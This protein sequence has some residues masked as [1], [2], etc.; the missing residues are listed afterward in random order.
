MM[1]PARLKLMPLLGFILSLCVVHPVAKAQADTWRIHVL[2]QLHVTFE[3][4]PGYEQLLHQTQYEGPD[5]VVRRSWY[6]RDT[7]L[8]QLCKEISSAFRSQIKT[9]NLVSEVVNLPKGP[10]CFITSQDDSELYSAVILPYPAPQHFRWSSTALYDLIFTIRKKY[11]RQFAERVNFPP[12]LSPALYVEGVFELLKSTYYLHNQI[13]WNA[14]HRDMLAS[15]NGNN[16]MD[17]A[18]K[19]IKVTTTKFRELKD[20]HSYFELPAEAAATLRGQDSSMGI[21]ILSGEDGVIYLIYP[22]SPGAKAGLRVGDVLQTINGKPLAMYKANPA[23]KTLTLVVLRKSEPSPLTITV[24]SGSFQTYIPATGRR[25]NGSIGYIE[26]LGIDGDEAIQQKYAY[27]TQQAIRKV[28]NSATCGWIVDLRRNQGGKIAA[29]FSGIAP[30]IGEGK[31]FGTSNGYSDIIWTTYEGGLFSV[32]GTNDVNVRLVWDPYSLKLARPPIAVLTS[33]LTASGGEFTAIALLKRSE[34][35]T[36]IFGEHTR[37]LTT[38]LNG[39]WLY[40]DA[41]LSIATSVA[42]DRT[43]NPYLTGVEPDEKLSTDF[44]VFGSDDDPV[45]RTAMKWLSNQ[46]TCKK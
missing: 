31:L 11:L 10:A 24:S 44:S 33:E 22:D 20:N 1:K 21:K 36:R 4:P 23:D 9:G 37:G 2:H 25:L 18:H 40:D 34:A 41:Y 17:G 7:P 42:T 39:F 19:A 35:A 13:D 30:M 26:T 5:G 45:L 12:S 29:I 32:P 27:D 14:L 15:L 3:L 43:G 16:T 6:M 28:D 8:T 38:I 46:P